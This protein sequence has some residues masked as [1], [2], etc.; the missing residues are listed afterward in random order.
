LKAFD[1]FTSCLK[2]IKYKFFCIRS[3][4]N[5]AYNNVYWQVVNN[6]LAAIH[7]TD[8]CG[9]NTYFYSYKILK[10]LVVDNFRKNYEGV[11]FQL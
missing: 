1:A 9:N 3:R 6:E 5:D 10:L 4:L 7:I 11:V 2:N 8:D